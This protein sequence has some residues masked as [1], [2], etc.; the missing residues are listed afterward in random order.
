MRLAISNTFAAPRKEPLAEMFSRIYHAFLTAGLGQPAIRFT[1]SDPILPDGVSAVDRVLTRHP[2][3]ARFVTSAAPMHF[4]PEVRRI[5]NAPFTPTDGEAVP[6]ATLHA[7]AAGVP[8]SF[9]FHAVALHLHSPAFG[10]FDPSRV[11]GG[12]AG[13]GIL[14][15]DSWWISGRQRGLASCYFIAPEP[16]SKKL[17]TPPPAVAAVLAACGKAKKTVQVPM[18]SVS[19]LAQENLPLPPDGDSTGQP[20]RGIQEAVQKLA[21]AANVNPDAAQ[22][23]ARISAEYRARMAEV[24]ERAAPPHDLQPALEALRSTP[25]GTSSG[26][27]KPILDHH[28][29]PLGYSCKGGPGTFTLRRRT[30]HNNTLEISMD[31]GTWSNQ[32]TASLRVLGL[33]YR[34][35]LRLPVAARALDAMQYPIGDRWEEI[36]EN[37][38]AIVKEVEKSFVEEVETAVGT[39]PSWYQPES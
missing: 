16:D 8:R 15:S 20:A 27:K 33:G 19:A 17:P 35:S 3:L 37:L 10:E 38:A 29:R 32:V 2:E 14:I 31:V 21:A 23:A 25:L 34:A 12:D 24:I 22:A 6:F 18:H 4:S 9:P 36:V 26:P 5:T 28:F 30:T 11:Q 13:S 7:I 39:S 1:F